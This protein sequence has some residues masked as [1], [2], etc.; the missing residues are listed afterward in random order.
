MDEPKDHSARRRR[1]A[2][3]LDPVRWSP[4]RRGRLVRGGL[5]AVLLALAA[6]VLLTG[7]GTASADRCVARSP[8]TAPAGSRPPS[9]A[10]SAGTVPAGAV[11]LAV[12]VSQPGAAG[13][14]R[15]GDRV[16]LTVARSDGDRAAILVRGALV[17]R[18]TPGHSADNAGE[19][20][21]YLAMS[22]DEARR[23]AGTEPSARIGIAL[24]PG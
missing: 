14:V 15:P 9:A 17:L 1:R 6:G 16:D 5:V 2:D 7:A 4:R 21:V 11:G 20:V 12:T 8:S 13:L 22:E 10:T 18:G 3:R 24:R 23:V 19:S